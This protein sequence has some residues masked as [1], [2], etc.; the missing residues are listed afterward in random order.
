V[1]FSSFAAV[2]WIQRRLLV[3]LGGHHDDGKLVLLVVGVP[4]TCSRLKFRGLNTERQVSGRNLLLTKVIFLLDELGVGYGTGHCLV[5]PQEYINLTP[6]ERDRV[7]QKCRPS[8]F[9][10]HEGRTMSREFRFSPQ[11]YAGS[12]NIIELE[13]WED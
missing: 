11:G 2:V 6:A 3:I 1:L 12:E 10:T 13:C 4:D 7:I 5:L 8:C 9:K